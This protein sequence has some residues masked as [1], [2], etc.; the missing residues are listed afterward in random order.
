MQHDDPYSGETYVLGLKNALYMPAM[1]NNLIPPFLLREAGLIVDDVPKSQAASPTIH[2]HSIYFP[3]EKF[4]IPLLLHGIFSYFPSKK[5]STNVLSLTN[6][7]NVL[8]LTSGSINPH[9]KIFSENER[10]MVDH[11]GNMR[12][13]SERTAIILEDI[14]LDPEMEAAA[15]IS[16]VETRHTSNDNFDTTLHDD[17]IDNLG[18]KLRLDGELSKLKMAIGACDVNESPY[19]DDASIGTEPTEASTDVSDIDATSEAEDE[20][21]YASILDDDSVLNEFM[22]GG[23]TYTKPSNGVSA[24]HLSKIWKISE[25]DAEKTINIT[26][27]RVVR[28]EDPALSHNYSSND[29]MLRCKRLDSHFFMDTFCATKGCIHV[30][31]MRKESE[32]LLALKI[33]GA[34]VAHLSCNE[35][36]PGSTPGFSLRAR[37]AV[38]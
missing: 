36:M 27:Q 12:E 8:F 38:N 10:A 5:P 28:T 31:P 15:F 18:D 9:S 14:A 2:H 30:V 23:T 24:K 7:N 1:D 13:K 22:V 26:T 21:D 4:R 37:C 33:E 35:K 34:V 20:I 29:R 16:D 3:D 11:E 32:V 19:L 17:V 6:N 25:K